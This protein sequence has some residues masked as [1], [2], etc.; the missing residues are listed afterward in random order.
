MRG[1]GS[2][3]LAES[4][5]RLL[6][7]PDGH[8]FRAVAD[9]SYRPKR[10][11]DDA[12]WER[13]YPL[14]VEILAADPRRLT[15]NYRRLEVRRAAL[16][17]HVYWLAG[18]YPDDLN[19]DFALDDMQVGRSGACV[20]AD[21]AYRSQS[22]F[23]SMLRS[24][25]GGYPALFSPVP[26]VPQPNRL[27][28]VTDSEFA[29]ALGAAET[30]L[31]PATRDHVRALLLLSRGAGADGVDCRYVVGSDVY[32]R[33]GA[34]LWVRMTRP[35]YEREVP[36]LKRFAQSLEE[37]AQR[38]GRGLL[39]S[40]SPPPAAQG[41]CSELA[42]MLLRRT[43]GSYPG[44]HV[45]AMRV[46]KA[47]LLEQIATWEKLHVFL[48]ASG[49]QTV[50]SVDELREFWSPATTDPARMAQL[51]GGISESSCLTSLS[52]KGTG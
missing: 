11:D 28:P 33:P 10:A 6:A 12:Q 36:V 38:A 19:A 5:E 27:T 26:A 43:K 35:G 18:E 52:S 29:I 48:Q 31:S 34:G 14:L 49:L 30:F 32:R 20:S 2:A 13:A 44:L 15:D 8:Q 40:A 25:R 3:R 23:K 39:V 50:H 41:V 47:W 46:R 17:R 37:L 7:L 21:S 4:L 9:R 24:F 22:S 42:G 16:A 51:L 1:V 45:S